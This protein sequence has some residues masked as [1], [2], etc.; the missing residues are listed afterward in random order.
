VLICETLKKQQSLIEDYNQLYSP[1]KTPESRQNGERK[2]K[3]RVVK[4]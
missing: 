4:L 3:R 2:E 1:M